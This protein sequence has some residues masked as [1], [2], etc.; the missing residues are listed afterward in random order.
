MAV[1]EARHGSGFTGAAVGQV[2]NLSGRPIANRPQDT[3]LPHNG[4]EALS[5]LTLG[6]LRFGE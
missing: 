5:M 4:P 2:D 1:R 6:L 3:I